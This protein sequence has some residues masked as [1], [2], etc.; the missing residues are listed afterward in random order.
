M[1]ESLNKSFSGKECGLFSN[2]HAENLPFENFEDKVLRLRKKLLSLKK[3]MVAFSGGIDS[4][5]LVKTAA[6]ILGENCIAVTVSSCFVPKKEIESAVSFCLSQKIPHIILKAE[7]LLVEGIAENPKNRCYRCKKSIFQMILEEAEKNGIEYVLEGTNVS[8]TGDF[9]P[10]LKALGELGILSPF[11]EC[12]FT[13]DEIRSA[14]KNSG[15]AS[16]NKPST[17]CLASRFVYGENLT[18]EKLER[19]EAAEDFLHGLG[20][21]QLRVRVHKN[22][23]RIEVTEG[24]MENLFSTRSKVL[25]KLKSLGFDYVT[26]DLGGFKSGSMNV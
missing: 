21:G 12:G 19:V 14:S 16:W 20:F 13:K 22:L 11:L 15:L 7:P 8:D 18:K 17:A 24:E 25:Q 4:Q 1:S 3:V 10:G 9:R 2:L 6:D 5:F 23:A 26:F